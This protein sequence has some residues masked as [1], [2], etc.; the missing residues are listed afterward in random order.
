[1]SQCRGF[2]APSPFKCGNYVPV[3]SVYL[4]YK[5]LLILLF[6][7]SQKGLFQDLCL[8]K[9]DVLEFLFGKKKNRTRSISTLSSI[10]LYTAS[11]T[12]EIVSRHFSETQ[13]MTAAPPK[14]IFL[15][16]K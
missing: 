6:K 9:C 13:S 4:L 11:I 16:I 5:I 15:N 3:A 14:Q 10:Q 1:M 7:S 12:I 8:R 2:A